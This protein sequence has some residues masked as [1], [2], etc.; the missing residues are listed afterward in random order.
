MAASKATAK[1]GGAGGGVAEAELAALQDKFKEQEKKFEEF[2]KMKDDMVKEVSRIEAVRTQKGEK[3]G[4][5]VVTG[6]PL[7]P[8]K[9]QVVE[10][11]LKRLEDD[12]KLLEDSIKIVQSKQESRKKEIEDA[13]A[14]AAAA[15]EAKLEKERKDREKIRA[16]Q[17]KKMKKE[18]DASIRK[19]MEDMQKN[20]LES[21]LG[22]IEARL[23]GI[24]G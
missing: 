11:N 14:A 7:D 18:T 15:T 12:K 1:E 21:R 3:I 8:A 6:E 17:L 20:I 19:A 4:E 16:E 10:S 24:G 9:M 22:V 13:V 2:S 5:R 23:K